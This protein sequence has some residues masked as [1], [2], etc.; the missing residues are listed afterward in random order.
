MNHI[1]GKILKL[2]STG[3]I[4]SQYGTE[5]VMEQFR[6]TLHTEFPRTPDTPDSI[7]HDTLE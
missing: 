6:R 5:L 7:A 4:M 2:S 3:T 1:P